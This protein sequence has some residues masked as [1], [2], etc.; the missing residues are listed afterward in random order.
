MLIVNL[1]IN[2]VNRILTLG[3]HNVSPNVSQEF[4]GEC[5]Y[6]I[7]V[8]DDTG[9]RIKF[10]IGNPDAQVFHYREDGAEILAAKALEKISF[11]RE[12]S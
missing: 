6:D 5:L 11:I 2:N 7:Y 9:G 3:I 4:E 8:G 1:Q 10:D 12:N